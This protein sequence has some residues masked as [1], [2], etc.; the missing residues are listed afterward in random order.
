VNSNGLVTTW[1]GGSVTIRATAGSAEGTAAIEIASAPEGVPTTVAGE[2][3]I[4]WVDTGEPAGRAELI[5]TPG[6]TGVVGAVT[7]SDGSIYDL[8]PSSTWMDEQLTLRWAQPTPDGEV[9]V[10]ID[11]AAPLNGELLRGPMIDQSTAQAGDV[12]VSRVAE[13]EP[14]LVRVEVTPD[15]LELSGPGATGQLTATGFDAFDAPIEGLDFAWASSNPNVVTVSSAGVVNSVAEGQ[16]TVTAT[17][18]GVTG[19]SVVVVSA[20][21]PPPLEPT[22]VVV[23]PSSVEA[24]RLAELQ[25]TATVFDQF[26]DEMPQAQVTW[27]SSNG[28]RASVDSSGLV[29]TWIGGSVAISA[30][31]GTAQ[32]S[33]AVDI[34]PAPEGVPTTVAGGWRICWVDTGEPTGTAELVHSS[35][36]TEVTGTVTRSDGSTYNLG[37]TSNWTD[38]Q[39]TLRWSQPVSGGERAVAIDGATPLNRELLRGPMID[40]ASGQSGEVFVS[41]VSGGEPLVDRIE[42]TPDTVQLSGPGASAQLTAA[43]FD[44][45][46]GPIDGLNFDWASSDPSIVT[47]DGSGL[48]TAVASGQA[49]VT[50][51]AQGVIGSALVIVASAPPEPTSLVV[52]PGVAEVPRLTEIAFTATVYDQFGMEMPDIEVEWTSSSPCIASVNDVGLVSA[53]SGGAVSI[54]ASAGSLQDSASL[55]IGGAAEG[56]PSTV[57]GRWRLCRAWDGLLLGHVDITHTAGETQVTGTVTDPFGPV[58]TLSQQSEWADDQLTLIWYVR[59]QGGE[60][61]QWLNR[62][63]P[64][65]QEVIFGPFT[66]QISGQTHDVFLTRVQGGN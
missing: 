10:A 61:L 2:W 27:S 9:A 57:Q 34:A 12:F 23:S 50:A 13:G 48:V 18:E 17:A 4:C 58:Y 6:E 53:W 66:S 47:V 35:G 21:P 25:F 39:L 14:S 36:A 24:E 46:D 20:E 56:I 19:S 64:L 65:N 45:S 59:F 44:A 1:I 62:G 49:A 54:T 60:R 33:A 55:T 32:D 41:R 8:G 43:A 15:T 11:G 30:T 42:V 29:T 16:A 7:R 31:A 63:E 22:T 37:L 38:E 28:C 5:H 52:E 3:R 51:S 26:G 40:Q